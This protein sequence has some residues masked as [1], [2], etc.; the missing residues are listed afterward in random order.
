MILVRSPLRISFVGG[1]TDLAPFFAQHPGR[2]VSATINKF[3]YVVVNSTPL[4]NKI[5]VKYQKTEQVSHP[6]ELEHPSIKAALIDLGLLE[7]GVEIGSFA[8]LPSK[9]GLGSSSS[10]S[11]AL[12]KGLH[13]Y[14]GR[15]LSKK[16]AAEAACRLEID[17]LAEPIGKQ[18]QYAAAFG[19]FNLFQ[20]NPDR[21]VD[22]EPL[23]LDYKKRSLLEDHLLLFFTG[24]TRSASSVL[25]EQHSNINNHLETY[26]KMAGA[27][28]VFSNCLMEG[29]MERMAALLRE[30]WLH[31]KKLA[32]TITNALIN[33]FYESG[34]ASGALAGKILGA[35]GG[36]SLL[37]LA[38]PHAHENIID[39]LETM[40]RK[41]NLA[42]WKHIPFKFVQS[43]TDIIFNR[44]GNI[45]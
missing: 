21:S 16:E 24:I 19:G 41:N 35:G 44:D 20:F 14:R 9:I 30:G 40:A 39:M 4:I 42:E 1:G 17:L 11:V 45:Y 27:A 33:E 8:D 23:L 2:V 22:V 15:K 36:G 37:F 13:A 18:D 10:F 25:R 31:K 26:K 28:R 6:S 3:V 34:M 32:S 5:T 7:Q 12:M 43:G 29:D 38:P